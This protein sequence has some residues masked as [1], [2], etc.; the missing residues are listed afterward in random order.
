MKDL[1]LHIGTHKTGTTALQYF[2][3]MNQVLLKEKGIEYPL[4]EKMQKKDHR[5]LAMAFYPNHD[6]PYCEVISGIKDPDEE[7]S[8]FIEARSEKKLLISSE[9]FFICSPEIISKIREIT[10][11]YNVKVICYIR[12]Q[13][14]LEESWYNQSIK[15]FRSCGSLPVSTGEYDTPK[16]FSG[17]E[18]IFGP[19]NMIVRPYEKEQFYG[20]CIFSDFLHHVFDIELTD[21]F[22]LPEKR[23]NA[24]LHRITLEYQRLIN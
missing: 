24:R 14:E 4:P 11:T 2:F 5:R 17:W 19:E 15:G 9:Q 21:E 22:V 20:G 3:A 10:S 12:R 7:W 1:Y 13:D 23:E 6:A 18:D 16:H 8:G